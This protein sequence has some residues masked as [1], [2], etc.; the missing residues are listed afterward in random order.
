MR[1]RLNCDLFLVRDLESLRVCCARDKDGFGASR[2]PVPFQAYKA[3]RAIIAG[4][5]LQSP[6]C[7]S[8]RENEK[9]GA[10]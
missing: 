10:R 6:A 7:C 8:F 1:G 4:A 9:L 3:K 2:V 5:V